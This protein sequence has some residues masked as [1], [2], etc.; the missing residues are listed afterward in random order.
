MIRKSK[1]Y[2]SDKDLY[3]VFKTSLIYSP[4]FWFEKMSRIQDYLRPKFARCIHTDAPAANVP[5]VFYQGVLEVLL[6]LV[7]NM[8]VRGNTFIWLEVFFIMI[9][10][11]EINKYSSNFTTAHTHTI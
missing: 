6:F 2:V 8:C 1:S 11:L 5:Y 4:F 7:F 10:T 9:L 3:K